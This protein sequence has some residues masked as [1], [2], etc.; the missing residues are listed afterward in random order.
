MN[1]R[2]VVYGVKAI[3]TWANKTV[4]LSI[5]VIFIPFWHPSFR[6]LP[7][8]LKIIFTFLHNKIFHAS[9][10]CERKA[11]KLFLLFPFF[12]PIPL[13][14]SWIVVQLQ[15]TKQFYVSLQS[16]SEYQ[17]IKE[18][19]KSKVSL[20]NCAF[21]LFHSSSIQPHTQPDS[22]FKNFHFLGSGHKTSWFYGRWSCTLL[23]YYRIKNNLLLLHTPQSVLY[24]CFSISNVFSL[25]LLC[26]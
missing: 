1:I 7:P 17:N 18:K 25:F 23:I 16:P 2:R 5:V 14:S 20:V 3:H 26:Y 19:E 4:I 15:T 6:P 13:H 21:H 12:L 10:V 22:L 24:Q 8:T 11:K 9:C